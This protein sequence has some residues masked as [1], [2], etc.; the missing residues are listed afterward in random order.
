MSLILRSVSHKYIATSALVLDSVD[1]AIEDGARI[2]ITGPSGSGKST[3]LGILG[4]LLR[5][6]RGE[7]LL[8]G[9]PIPRSYRDLGH[10]F[11]WVFQ[12]VNALGRRSVEDNIELP[13]LASGLPRTQARVIANDRLFRVGLADLSSALASSLSGGELQRMCIAR[14]MAGKPRFLLADEPTGQL[15][16]ATSV[17]VLDALWTAADAATIVVATHDREVS[18]RCDRSIHLV[19]GRI[20]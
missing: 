4:G 16:H 5:P 14:A 19:D 13:L 17:R 18:D 10:V 3:L 15:D 2:A 1:L 11:G 8:D 20:K 6:S 9:D 12:T 7:V